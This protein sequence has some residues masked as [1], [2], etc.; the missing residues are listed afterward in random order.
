MN[1]E[2]DDGKS[3]Q[4][5]VGKHRVSIAI[6][7]TVIIEAREAQ[8]DCK[9][10]ADV[11]GRHAVGEG[12][13]PPKPVGDFRREG[14]GQRFHSWDG[15]TRHS[16]VEEEVERNGKDV[17]PRDGQ[18]HPVGEPAVVKICE[19]K[20]R[21][22]ADKHEPGDVKMRQ[23]GGQPV[24]FKRLLN[25]KGQVAFDG[26]N[27]RGHVKAGARHQQ[28]VRLIEHILGVV[29]G[30]HDENVD[31]VASEEINKGWERQFRPGRFEHREEKDA[32]GQGAD[33]P[34]QVDALHT[35]AS[36]FGSRRSFIKASSFSTLATR[37]V[38]Q[39]P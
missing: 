29:D 24:R 26:P 11:Q 1:A 6:P 17:D 9:R 4:Q 21:N 2:V 7:T 14:V 5:R 37:S 31:P 16:N 13:N 8:P 32:Q 20:H 3:R 39:A 18:G 19:I 30:K 33:H 34:C 28:P 22:V 12:V 38:Y 10:N 25:P 23:R 27:V 35:V 15:I 36:G